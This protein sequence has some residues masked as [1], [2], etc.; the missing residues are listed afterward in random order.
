MHLEL[1]HEVVRA[2]GGVGTKREAPT[3]EP[4]EPCQRRVVI[5]SPAG[6]FSKEEMSYVFE[7]C[8]EE[9]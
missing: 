3:F 2:G 1:L 9:I 4:R 6:K 7:C 5:P 8:L